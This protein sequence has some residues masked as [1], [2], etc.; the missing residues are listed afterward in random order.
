MASKSSED[1]NKETGFSAWIR[2]GGCIHP[3]D[4]FELSCV[5]QSEETAL[6][7]PR[8]DKTGHGCPCVAVLWLSFLWRYGHCWTCADIDFCLKCLIRRFGRSTTIPGAEGTGSGL[9]KLVFITGAVIVVPS[10]FFLLSCSIHL[11]YSSGA[12]VSAEAHQRQ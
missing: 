3:L 11:S 1:A 6:A 7:A 5:L 12:V 10:I 2:N 9:R 4:T 8:G